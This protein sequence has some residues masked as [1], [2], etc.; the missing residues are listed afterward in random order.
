M[1]GGGGRTPITG[2]EK[3]AYLRVKLE[4][5]RVEAGPGSTNYVVMARHKHLITSLAQPPTSSSFITRLARNT[6]SS[7]SF[8]LSTSP[9]AATAPSAA[10]AAPP[11]FTK[12]VRHQ[13]TA[14]EGCQ[15]V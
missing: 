12:S 15:K 11:G 13:A 9:A 14:D 5:R 6:I 2:R 8:L 3:C 4:A 1:R 7:N 10:A